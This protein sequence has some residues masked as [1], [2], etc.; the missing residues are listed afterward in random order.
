MT[1]ERYR[2]RTKI[3]NALQSKALPFS[4]NILV[5]CSYFIQF[6]KLLSLSLSLCVRINS[7][8]SDAKCEI[9]SL[10]AGFIVRGNKAAFFC[11][12]NTHRIVSLAFVPFLFSRSPSHSPA[13]NSEK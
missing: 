1:D 12:F 9:R 11:L 8:F 6:F 4:T 3:Y 2:T 13:M 10:C 5:F 7:L